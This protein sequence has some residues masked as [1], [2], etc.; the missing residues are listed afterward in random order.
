MR[1]LAGECNGE[2]F[3]IDFEEGANNNS[4][5]VGMAGT[6]KSTFV[7]SILFRMRRS[8]RNN[9]IVIDFTGE[10][11]VL[12]KAGFKHL[13]PGVNFYLNPFGLPEGRDI[14]LY[15]IRY[16]FGREITPIQLAIISDLTESYDNLE[17]MINYLRDRISRTRDEGL[18]NA[19][20]AVLN[21]IRPLGEFNIFRGNSSLP[22]GL[23]HL[24]LAY[25]PGNMVKVFFTITLLYYLYFMALRGEYTSFIVIDEAER[26]AKPFLIQSNVER[27][28]VTMVYDELRKYGLFMFLITHTLALLDREVR[29]N[30]RHLFVFKLQDPDDVSLASKMLLVRYEDVI[31]TRRYHFWYKPETTAAV[32]VKVLPEPIVLSYRFRPITP[33][34]R[35]SFR[36]LVEMVEGLN[37]T[38]VEKRIMRDIL[39]DRRLLEAMINRDYKTI[40]ESF[41]ELV[42][43]YDDGQRFST[44]GQKLYN[45]I[46]NH[47]EKYIS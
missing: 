23:L 3:Y 29:N 46:K 14:L 37:L 31:N 2:E 17:D 38:D 6:G 47:M 9:I 24:N 35:M 4:L 15:Y 21:R 33:I 12:E 11:S 45:I 39:S 7:K 40:G 32:R 28:I 44:M 30:V 42:K 25:L 20:S 5:F 1:V 34:R 19:Y 8:I 18:R 13:I 26:V 43:T 10:Y 16:A 27:N 36:N 41:P 22:P